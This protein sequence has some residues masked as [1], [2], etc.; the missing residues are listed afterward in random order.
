MG[1]VDFGWIVG[2]CIGSCC[3]GGDSGNGFFV[4]VIVMGFCD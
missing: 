4:D 3:V 2:L 1:D